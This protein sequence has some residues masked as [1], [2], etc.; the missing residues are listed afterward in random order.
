MSHP[1]TLSQR[2]GLGGDGAQFYVHWGPGG[3]NE[4]MT[5]AS[6]HKDKPGIFSPTVVGGAQERK[7][8]T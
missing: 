5:R 8:P 2:R 6:S 7:R 1:Q 3:G 4:R